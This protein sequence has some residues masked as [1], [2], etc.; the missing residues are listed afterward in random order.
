MKMSMKELLNKLLNWKGFIFD[1]SEQETANTTNTW[2]PVFN[3]AKIQH[4][5]IPVT[6][7][8]LPNVSST[9]N[10]NTSNTTT[11]STSGVNITTLSHKTNTGKYLV[12]AKATYKTNNQTS[13]MKVTCAGTQIAYDV[14]NDTANHPVTLFGVRTTSAD[15]TETIALVMTPQ[16]GSTATSPAYH[17]YGITAIDIP[18]S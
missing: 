8:K 13:N 9:S 12:I 5:V 17:T 10:R 14:T 15:A 11:T 1:W 18:Y 16:S 4:R 7:N 2:V 6:Y 3:Y